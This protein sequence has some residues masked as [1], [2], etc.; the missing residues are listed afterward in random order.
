MNERRRFRCQAHVTASGNA[1]DGNSERFLRTD[2]GRGFLGTKTEVSRL[3]ISS[4]KLIEKNLAF[5][6]RAGLGGEVDSEVDQRT[7][8]GLELGIEQSKVGCT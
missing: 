5:R 8:F 1:V 7:L 4:S 2:I 6:V 3:R